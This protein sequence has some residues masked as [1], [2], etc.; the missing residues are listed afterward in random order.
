VSDVA[1]LVRVSRLYYELG[2]TQGR[3]AELLGVTRPQVSKLL[4]Q[5][6][7]E[8]IVEIRIHDRPDVESP[9]AGELRDRFGLR[10]VHLAPGLAGPEDLT[11]RAVGRL[12]AHV[13]HGTVRDGRVIGIGD[14]AAIS[15][16]ADA[17]ADS[18][19]AS[20]VAATV[21]PLCGGYWL[22]GPAREPFRRI[23]EAV[24]AQAHGLLAP[25]LVDDAATK[26]ALVRHAGIR[27]VLELW[28]RLDVAAFGIGGRGWGEA[29]LGP[30]LSRELEAR[31]A[32]GEVLI[33]P[34][35]L[36]GR[37]VARDALRERTIAFDAADLPRVPTTVAVATGTSKV[38]PILGALRAGLVNVLVTDV[39]TAG[40][41][42]AL[43][44]ETR[45]PPM[46][47][48]GA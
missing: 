22:A 21:V 43:D 18:E 32:V 40:A 4:K 24:G 47:E 16:T 19:A 15:A 14:G 13:L 6:R 31:G 2:E 1:T 35:D 28:E 3:I 17:M 25:G 46:P 10:E 9:A 8:G 42:V 12:A 11:R 5:A 45:E 7:S 23:A 34:F 30:K 27:S 29:S 37:F 44:D 48:V 36:D 20:P 39:E 41:V 38:A 26:S 33:A